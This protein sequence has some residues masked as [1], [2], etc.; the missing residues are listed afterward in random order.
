MAKRLAFFFIVLL[1]L[2]ALGAKVVVRQNDIRVT[3]DTGIYW[4][5]SAAAV[6][7]LDAGIERHAANVLEVVIGVGGALGAI[8]VR[9]SGLYFNG[10]TVADLLLQ[11]S[12]TTLNVRLGD[13]TAYSDVQLEGLTAGNTITWGTGAGAISH[14]Q[15]PSDQPFQIRAGAGQVADIGT[16]VCFGGTTAA[17]PAIK[18]AATAITASLADDSGLCAI[19][20]RVVEEDHVAGDT[21]T[22][23]ESDSV[24]TNTGVA[25]V[26]TLTLPSAPIQGTLLTVVRTAAFSIHLDPGAADH[27]IY[28]GGTMTDGEALYLDTLGAKIQ[29]VADA[30]G[31]WV[32]T[33]ELGTLTEETP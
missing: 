27:F 3:S 13:D 4:A 30:N 8:V 18:R 14:L 1:A 9:D 29:V 25:A 19:I 5:D 33:Y 7:T 10:Q 20:R 11:R 32:A 26:T 21:L 12:G 2:L 17:F 24:H 6:T 28:S 16:F 31:D 22:V 23:S 15:G